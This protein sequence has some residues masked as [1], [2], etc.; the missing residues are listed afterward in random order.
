MVSV[1]IVK[2]IKSNLFMNDSFTNDCLKPHIIY[3]LS[4]IGNSEQSEFLALTAENRNTL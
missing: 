4:F 1:S 3:L 2:A